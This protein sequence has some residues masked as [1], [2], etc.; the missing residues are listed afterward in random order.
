MSAPVEL[1]LLRIDPVTAEPMARWAQALNDANPIH[2]DRAA[3]EAL[4][5]GQHTVNPGPTNLAY[6]I[7]LLLAAVPD[8]DIATIEARFL[9]NVL[10]EQSVVATGTLAGN[11][12]ELAVDR[13]GDG[14]PVLRVAATLRDDPA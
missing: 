14:Q 4:G 5:F 8:R 7:N 9:G 12:G 3:A 13:I 11:Q 1:P 10:S 6:A 2:S